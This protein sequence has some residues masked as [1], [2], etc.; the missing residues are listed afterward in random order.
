MVYVCVC[1]T[2]ANVIFIIAENAGKKNMFIYQGSFYPVTASPL[3]PY[4]MH[5]TGMGN[6]GGGGLHCRQGVHMRVRMC[7]YVRRSK[8][9]HVCRVNSY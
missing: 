8:C 5:I 3:L 4:M 9:V 2:E 7:V 1:V 6:G